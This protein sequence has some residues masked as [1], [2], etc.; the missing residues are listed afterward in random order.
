MVL[1]LREL[2]ADARRLQEKDYKQKWDF[3][4]LCLLFLPQNVRQQ[5][6]VNKAY[7]SM[8]YHM[9]QTDD[10]SAKRGKNTDKK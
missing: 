6:S 10:Q 1:V 7:D 3:L 5:M 4:F 8:G 9:K 2:T